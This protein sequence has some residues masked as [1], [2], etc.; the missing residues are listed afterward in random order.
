MLNPTPALLRG[1]NAAEQ[2]MV[3]ACTIK[4]RTGEVTDGEFG[5]VT[6]SY[7]TVYSGKCK[8]KRQAAGGGPTDVGQASVFI[9]SL[10]VHIPVSVTGVSVDDLITITASALDSALVGRVYRVRDVLEKSF[11]TARRLACIEVNG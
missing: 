11:L 6:P 3:D 5:T 9:G 10:E 2:L 1:R 4:H 7:S 8:V